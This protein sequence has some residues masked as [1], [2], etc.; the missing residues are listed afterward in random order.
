MSEH[1][2]PTCSNPPAQY[3]HLCLCA[4][5]DCYRFDPEQLFYCRGGASISSWREDGGKGRKHECLN[6]GVWQ[7]YGVRGGVSLR[8]DP[9]DGT[10][11]GWTVTA[12]HKTTPEPEWVEAVIG[13]LQTHPLKAIKTMAV[14]DMDGCWIMLDAYI[15]WS[16]PGYRPLPMANQLVL[17]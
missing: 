10:A 16:C 13:W 14:K 3:C 12:F 6:I 4:P 15:K 1:R 7:E 17:L 9:L 5:R 2:T 8:F 11:D